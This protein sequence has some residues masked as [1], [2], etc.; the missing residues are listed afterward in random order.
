MFRWD[1]QTGALTSLPT[2]HHGLIRSL[3]MSPDGAY[4]ASISRQTDSNVLFLDPNKGEVTRRFD[5]HD[6]CGAYVAVSPD[7]QFLASTSDDAT[8]KL[9]N[10]NAPANLPE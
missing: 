5:K 3:Q 8:I 4:I 2:E 1:L 10:L 7:G 9:W 6:L